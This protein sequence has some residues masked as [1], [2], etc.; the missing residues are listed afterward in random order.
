MKRRVGIFSLVILTAAAVG[1]LGTNA[2][3]QKLN[4]YTIPG[5]WYG[6]VT[7]TVDVAQGIKMTPDAIRKTVA[8]KRA[9]YALIN[10]LFFK[11][12]MILDP[13]EMAAPY[14]GKMVFV[15]G[16]IQTHSMQK[17]N[18]LVVNTDTSPGFFT[19]HLTSVKPHPAEPDNWYVLGNTAGVGTSSQV[20]LRH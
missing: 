7:D 18:E 14:A 4:L 2:R 16:I 20:N 17:G 13:A 1:F 8:E 3:A 10:G 11:A 12:Y 9:N 19:V 5:T 15:T 6:Y